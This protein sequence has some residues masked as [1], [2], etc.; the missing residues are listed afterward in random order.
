MSLTVANCPNIW[1]AN[2][3]PTIDAR[4]V[5]GVLRSGLRPLSLERL[6]LDSFLL[7]GLLIIGLE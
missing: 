7:V 4:R 6:I 5:D 1:Y 2:V 3:L